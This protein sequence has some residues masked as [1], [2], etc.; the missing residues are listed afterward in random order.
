MDSKGDGPTL[1]V[2]PLR[3]EALGK[4]IKPSSLKELS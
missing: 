1:R 2:S 3:N 4:Y